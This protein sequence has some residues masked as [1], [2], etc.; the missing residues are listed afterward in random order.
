MAEKEA[1]SVLT[2]AGTCGGSSSGLVLDHGVGLLAHLVQVGDTQLAPLE[3]VLD[4]G[5]RLLEGEEAGIP[6]PGPEES[7]GHTEESLGVAADVQHLAEATVMGT[8]TSLAVLSDRPRLL[9]DYFQ[10]LF[11]QVTNPPLDGIREELVTQ[12]ATSIGP[13]GNLLEPTP[14]ACRQLKLKTP[15]LDNAELAKIRYMQRG[16]S[17]I[18]WAI[19]EGRSAARGVDLYLMG[20]SDLPAPLR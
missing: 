4:V 6:L 18:V 15:I 13:E 10:Q 16:Q 17:L 2:P 12:I 5:S 11:A 8:D 7:Q 14:E 9:Y 20:K 19:A 3:E 1:R